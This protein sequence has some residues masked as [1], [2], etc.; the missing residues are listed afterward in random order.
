M[1]G[2]SVISPIY[3]SSAN[4]KKHLQLLRNLSS[5]YLIDMEI[6]IVDT[7]STDDSISIAEKFAD[8]VL[9]ASGVTR[10]A[11]R[12][13]GAQ[14]ANRQILVF[15]DSDCEIT[16]NWIRSVSTLPE[17]LKRRVLGGPVVLDSPKNLLEEPIRNLLLDPLFTFNSSSFSLI[18][19]STAVKELPTANLL[20]SKT[21]FREIGGFPD[22]D[23]NEDTLFCQKVRKQNGHIVYDK[24]LE[25][26][27][28]H[29]FLSTLSF[30]RYFFNYG[31]KYANTLMRNPHLIRR[32]AIIA[33]VA[34]FI[35]FTLVF[36]AT[37]PS[38]GTIIGVFSIFSFTGLLIYSFKKFGTLISG[39]IPGFFFLLIMSYLGGFYYGLFKK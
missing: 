15:L 32:Y 12:N 31:K 2:V 30:S 25:V 34:P 33:L 11:A 36:L 4:L 8:K 28:K 29:H 17:D 20:L 14:N 9:I 7:G 13:L 23:F 5:K 19:E 18:R 26:I 38:V 35:L 1:V 21:F 16:E 22:V 27:H 37:F 39:L 24:N 3:N 10:G 6:I